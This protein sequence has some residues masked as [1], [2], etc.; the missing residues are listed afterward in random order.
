MNADRT[1]TLDEMFSRFY[2]GKNTLP[3]NAKALPR[4]YDQLKAPVRVLR[5][6]AKL[7]EVAAYIETGPDH[8]AHA[9]NYCCIASGSILS[10]MASSKKK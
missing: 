8:Y 5:K 3:A 9:E 6:N 7:Q 4:Y 1:R 2:E 10:T